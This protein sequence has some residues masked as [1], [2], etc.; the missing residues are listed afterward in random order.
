MSI[1]CTSYDDAA[2]A[3]RAVS[4][5]LAAGIDG[6]HVRV[7]MGS[8][9]HGDDPAGSFAGAVDAAAP[10]GTFAGQTSDHAMG[11]FAG[12]PHAQR[13]GSFATI[14][15]ETVT[16]YADHTR[17]VRDAG[18]HAL[19]RLLVDAGLDE[20]AAERDVAALHEGRVLVLVRSDRP[21]DELLEA[22]S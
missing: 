13:H 14:D 1:Y 16:T 4:R 5:L 3:E 22:T 19:K 2:A 12:D 18:H 8:P 17:Q 7:L 20:D 11:A 10:V 15:R 21:V 9:A 6:E